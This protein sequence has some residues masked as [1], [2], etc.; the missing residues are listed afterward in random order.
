MNIFYLDTNPKLCASYHNDK[1]IVKMP[2]ET[3]Q[4]LSTALYRNGLLYSP[5]LYKPT[6]LNHPCVL[7]AS[8]NEC[9][10]IWL[11]YLGLWMGREYT[12]RYNKNHKAIEVIKY[13]KKFSYIL[14]EGLPTNP[15]QCM[16]EQY[17]KSDPVQAYRDYYLHEKNFG[18]KASIPDFM[19]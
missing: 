7:W 4:I 9:N 1:H 6:H 8:E 13:C 11:C 5:R 17:F 18:Y 14:P 12:K 16:P 15:V 2:T 10:F 3:A 19:L